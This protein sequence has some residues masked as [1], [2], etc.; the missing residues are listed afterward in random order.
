MYLLLIL[1]IGIGKIK[2]R[3]R[4]EKRQLIKRSRDLNYFNR[5]VSK[6]SAFQ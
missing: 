5:I 4:Q 3:K 2:Q 1:S 6:V